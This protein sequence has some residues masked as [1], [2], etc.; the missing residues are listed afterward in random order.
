M[1]RSL[2][3]TQNQVGLAKALPKDQARD[4]RFPYKNIMAS[5]MKSWP[6]HE[7]SLAVT[8]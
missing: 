8:T 6:D 1:V 5:S 4:S 3:P 7:I 2:Q